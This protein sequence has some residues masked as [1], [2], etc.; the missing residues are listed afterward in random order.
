MQNDRGLRIVYYPVFSKPE[1]LTDTY[2]R[3][4]WYF[5]AVRHRIAALRMLCANHALQ[6]LDPPPYL[7]DSIAKLAP[8]A[9]D[10]IEFQYH[11]PAGR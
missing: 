11:S 7:D 3:A 4:V 6:P 5:H 9:A 2:F 10:F 1:D 8:H